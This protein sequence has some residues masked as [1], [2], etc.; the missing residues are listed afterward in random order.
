MTDSPL[1]TRQQRTRQAILDVTL[2]MVRTQG[3]DKVSWR[4]IARAV[5]YSPSG[6]Y[7]YF[8]S[9][10]EII[11]T[12]ASDGLAILDGYVAAV[13]ENLSLED[14]IVEAG[15]SY[16]RFAHDH[17]VRFELAFSRFPSE[18]QSIE[19]EPAGAYKR[20]YD[21]VRRGLDE[22]R[23]HT[24]SE[25]GADGLAYLLWSFFHGMASL[26]ITHLRDFDADFVHIDRRGIEAFVKGLSL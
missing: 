4:G 12:L 5:D 14:Q 9:K 10:D 7:E 23:L 16:I 18:R 6:L 26:Q 1:R 8:A 22:G 20:L 2:D 25:E 21:L 13:D 3:I 19:Q 24:L 17:P 15:L 11:Q